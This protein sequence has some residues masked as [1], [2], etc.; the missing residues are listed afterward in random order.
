MTFDVANEATGLTRSKRFKA[1]TYDAHERLDREITAHA[2]FSSR[3][4]Y[5]LFLM[6]QLQF[7]R[8][9]AA[10]YDDA[11]LD[12]LLPDLSGRRRLEQVEQDLADVGLSSIAG[13][14]GITFRPGTPAD[15]PTALGWL[16]VAEGSN[17]GAAF[18]L[19]SAEKLG[20]S[21]RFGARHLAG[22]P[23]GRGLHWRT[24]TQALDMAELSLDEENRL[25]AGAEAAFGRVYAL[26]QNE[27]GSRGAA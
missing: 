21:E 3:E 22:A 11:R 13:D 1:R 17:L 10:L 25:F 5:V 16:Y 23:E 12:A 26:V 15:I 18:L 8:D 9:I 2:P 14:E 4:R 27:F 7:H 20:F 6:V 19:K 24:F